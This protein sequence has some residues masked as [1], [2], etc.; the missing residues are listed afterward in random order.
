MKETETLVLAAL[1]GP[2]LHVARRNQCPGK[3]CGNTV[4]QTPSGSIQ[5]V[6]SSL[7]HKHKYLTLGL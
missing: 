7:A 3:P 1:C 2:G 4:H 6:A 5:H